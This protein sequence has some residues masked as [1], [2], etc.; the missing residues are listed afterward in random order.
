MWTAAKVALGKI[1]AK[2]QWRHVKGPMGALI[3]TLRAIGWRP[4]G[5]VRWRN[6][7]GVEWN[8]LGGKVDIQEM[9]DDM[10]T[11]LMQR[12][13]K[14]AAQ[15]FQGQGLQDGACLGSARRH[16]HSLQKRG[17]HKEAGCLRGVV[18]GT[19]WPALR[20]RE[21]RMEINPICP[22]CGKAEETATHRFWQ[23]EH[24]AILEK[25]WKAAED[26]D[27]SQEG[28]G[29]E[30]KGAAS[31][32]VEGADPTDAT[33]ADLTSGGEARLHLVVGV[34]GRAPRGE[35][36]RCQSADSVQEQAQ[37]EQAAARVEGQRAIRFD[38]DNEDVDP[39][40]L[41][42]TLDPDEGEL[43]QDF[44][45]EE[46]HED[47]G[48]Q[49]LHEYCAAKAQQAPPSGELQKGDKKKAKNPFVVTKGIVKVAVAQLAKGENNCLWNRGIV[50][51]IGQSDSDV[52]VERAYTVGNQDMAS[53]PC[54]RIK[55]Y[56]DGSGSRPDVRLRRCGWGVAWLKQSGPD[57]GSFS[58]GMFG[59]IGDEKHTVAKAELEALIRALRHVAWK[60]VGMTV[61][62]DCRYVVQGFKAKIWS[63]G[64]RI[65]HRDRWDQVA[66]LLGE[67]S[68]VEVVWVKAHVTSI[69]QE[70]RQLPRSTLVG[71]EC[72]DELAKRGAKLVQV[73]ENYRAKVLWTESIAW[74]VRRRLAAIQ[75][76]MVE[77]P[78]EDK[79]DAFKR[80]QA[81]IARKQRE[82]RKREDEKAELE[83]K[84]AKVSGPR[85]TS[86]EGESLPV[87]ETNHTDPTVAPFSVAQDTQ[88]RKRGALEEK[89]LEAWKKRRGSEQSEGSSPKRKSAE[90]VQ[91]AA[92]SSRSGAADGGCKV[93][94]SGA[95]VLR[96]E[97]RNLLEEVK[98]KAHDTHR[99]EG[100]GDLVWCAKC[101][102]LTT[103]GGAGK[104]CNLAKRCEAPKARG[105]QNLATL[106]RGFNPLD[107]VKRR[108]K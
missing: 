31:P 43:P 55:V 68:N 45:D 78:G 101:G 95:A 94:T 86:K 2:N 49:E 108:K 11:D 77:N 71:N 23:C 26:E 38:F 5:P 33:C 87:P 7:N 65:S 35:A 9:M 10:K 27:C 103:P 36:S 98:A 52:P 100:R 96:E 39:F 50:P 60:D 19:F 57:E 88:T 25:E 73:D 51:T 70:V 91:E 41:W 61:H 79:E 30:D 59:S 97:A 85:Q 83:T 80:R 93:S 32:V 46:P 42:E 106:S 62:S 14:G 63:R 82:K 66:E 13:W 90:L 67:A 15:H 29:S 107:T 3:V 92:A 37:S 76:Y 84:R 40:D 21:A 16:I 24:N 12:H 89:L 1:P 58:G 6:P 74:R 104:L 18:C 44:W 64:T 81:H 75:Q 17:R 69:M 34:R 22:R 56:V 28:T 47:E 4:I 102:S 54:Q 72:A 105:L 53:N 8:C 99:L 20:K 48:H